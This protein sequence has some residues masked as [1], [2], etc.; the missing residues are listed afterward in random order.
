MKYNHFIKFFPLTAF[1][2]TARLGGMNDIAWKNAFVVGGICTIAVIAFH[3]YK[4]MMFD[5]L[6]LGVNLFLLI[7]A[8]SFYGDMSSVLYYLG[9]YKGP[10]FLSCLFCVGLL[11]TLFS[12]AGFIGIRSADKKKIE[13]DSL[14]LLLLSFISIIWSIIT[15][16]YGLIISAVIPFIVLRIAYDYY[17]EQV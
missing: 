5:R 1:M 10:V 11:T 15:N 12:Q 13:N 2:L 7:G 9:V 16:K 17:R 14:Q 6:M 3:V 4:K 8:C